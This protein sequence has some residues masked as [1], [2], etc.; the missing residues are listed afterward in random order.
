MK[1]INGYKIE[2]GANLRYANL[3]DA[4]LS[5]ADLSDANLSYADLSD[6]NL[7]YANLRHANL[8]GADLSDANLSYADLSYAD[9]RGANLSIA[10][11]SIA[12]LSG[13]NLRGATGNGAQIRTLQTSRYLVVCTKDTIAIGC[14]QHSVKEW[15]EFSDAT[16]IALDGVYALEWWNKYKDIVITL[17]R[18]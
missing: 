13:A 12:N 1:V 9:L 5:Y 14:Q 6:A 10:N 4:N 3:I 11:L 15:E 2:S 18:E 16:I 8:I 17:A 7:S